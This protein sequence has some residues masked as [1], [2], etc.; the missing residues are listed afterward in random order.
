MLSSDFSPGLPSTI[1]AQGKIQG[2]GSEHSSGHYSG[3][4]GFSSGSGGQYGGIGSS[5]ASGSSYRPAGGMGSSIPTSFADAQR[6]ASQL[7]QVG[8]SSSRKDTAAQQ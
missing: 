5:S 3:S 7:S 2:F 8:R 4:G 6:A 1:I